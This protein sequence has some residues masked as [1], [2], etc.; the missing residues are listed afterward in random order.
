MKIIIAGSRRLHPP[1]A[2]ITRL[3]E[4]RGWLTSITEV[5][6]G[7]AAGVDWSGERWAIQHGVPIHKMRADWDRYGR[8]AGPIRNQLM[9]EY[10]D[11]LIAIWD[12]ESTGTSHMVQAMCRQRKPLYLVHADTIAAMGCRE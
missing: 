6:C 7:G 1:T 2:C 4:R 9:A 5:V 11:G 12:G 8:R 10:A 3:L